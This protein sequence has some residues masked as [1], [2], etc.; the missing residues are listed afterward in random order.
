MS[1]AAPSLPAEP[2]LDRAI[3]PVSGR[4][5]A[6]PGGVALLAGLGLGCAVLAAAAWRPGGRPEPPGPGAPARQVVAFEPAAPADPWSPP[7]LAQEGPAPPAAPEEPP[8]SPTAG[9]AALPPPA[10]PPR[11]PAPLMAYAARPAPGD[12]VPAVASAPGGPV[13]P[14]PSASDAAP[15][16]SPLDEL[17][18]G[19]AIGR[20]SARRVGDRSLM[21]LA[22][23]AIPCTLQTALDTATSGYVTC[24]VATDVW[25][26]NGAVVLLDRGARV[27]GEYRAG[28]RPGDRRIFVL[29][30][31]AVTPEGVA[32][33][34]ASPG[35]DALGRAGF[36]G[37]VDDRF[38]AR[39]GAAVLLSVVDGAP[40]ILPGDPAGSRA[41][42][43]SQAAALAVEGGARI[44]P[45]LRKPQG[46]EVV[47]LAA[48]DFDFSGVYS[49]KARRP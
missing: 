39:F 5:R 42:L 11:A 30:T 41:R 43:P 36:D 35:A 31:R 19:S 45:T 48:Q 40:A 33:D 49:L 2:P 10:P 32:I 46:S 26:D 13:R 17:R 44:G 12:P 1:E 38:W 28:L 21:I 9:P 16:A 15:A 34:L 14:T 37:E 20:A 24:L 7:S 29:W 47:I 27:L 4:A 8:G 22:G 6:R 23:A 3:T 18:R 25:S